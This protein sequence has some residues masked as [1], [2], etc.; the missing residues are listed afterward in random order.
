[1]CAFFFIL[2]L[3]TGSNFDTQDFWINRL[4]EPAPAIPLTIEEIEEGLQCA[5]RIRAERDR[6]RT[7]ARLDWHD[8]TSRM[9]AADSGVEQIDK[10]IN[11]FITRA[12]RSGMSS[13]TLNTIMT[14]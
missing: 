9:K 6:Q 3:P 4:H 8:Y 7:Q 1:M 13:T 2:F 12:L 5:Q 14:R 11:E 10:L